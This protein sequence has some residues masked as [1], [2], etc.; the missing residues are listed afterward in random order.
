MAK[1]HVT[2]ALPAGTLDEGD[3]PTRLIP[4]TQW[5]DYH[6]WPPL[7]RLRHLIFNAAPRKDSRGQ[8]FSGNGY[9]PAFIRVGRRILVDETR[10]FQIA[11]GTCRQDAA[12]AEGAR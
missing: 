6:P 3:T 1:Q 8:V 4:V 9:A 10:F 2:A 12:G 11:R 5:A 7:G